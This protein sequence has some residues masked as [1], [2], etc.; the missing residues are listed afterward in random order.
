MLAF[1]ISR[2]NCKVADATRRHFK[3]SQRAQQLKKMRLK[4][5]NTRMKRLR[6]EMEE[7]SEEQKKIKDGQRQVREKFEAIELECEQLRKETKLI[8]QQ[9]LSTQIRLALMFQILKARENHD[10]SKAS[11][12]TCVLRELIER[13]NQQKEAFTAN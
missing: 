4:N 5:L 13:E 6:V 10:F 12:L 11:Q 7:I 1:P 9:S 3:S 2:R 8:T